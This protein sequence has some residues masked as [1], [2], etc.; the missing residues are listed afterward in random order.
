MIICQVNGTEWNALLACVSVDNTKYTLKGFYID[1]ED[2]K[3]ISLIA[4]DGRRM[5]K[6]G[7]KK[8][9]CDPSPTALFNKIYSAKGLRK[10]KKNEIVW[11]DVVNDRLKIVYSVIGTD[12]VLRYVA[13]EMAGR[14]PNWRLYVKKESDWLNGD[15]REVVRF[16]SGLLFDLPPFIGDFYFG[17][18]TSQVIAKLVFKEAKN[19]NIPGEALF[20]FMPMKTDVKII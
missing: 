18:S 4:L 11:L 9:D 10:A 3:T 6:I 19:I 17:K 20:V 16:D 14:F 12:T 13:E 5:I 2:G 15:G 7:E 1:S 8:V